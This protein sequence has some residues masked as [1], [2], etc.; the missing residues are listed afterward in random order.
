ML[1]VV[2]ARTDVAYRKLDVG[3]WDIPFGAR[4]LKDVPALPYV[5]VFDKGG[6]R[7]DAISGLDVKRVDAAIAKGSGG[8]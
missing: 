6:A 1:A 7:V 3:D 5:V 4:Y 2:Q 8:S